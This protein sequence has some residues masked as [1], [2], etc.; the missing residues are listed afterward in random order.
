M[1]LIIDSLEKFLLTSQFVVDVKTC[2]KNARATPTPPAKRS[3][4]KEKSE[5]KETEVLIT[6]GEI[7]YSADFIKAYDLVN[8]A[9]AAPSTACASEG[10]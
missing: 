8:A 9:P 7:S 3:M 2:L 6:V 5:R 1:F 10:L 4:L